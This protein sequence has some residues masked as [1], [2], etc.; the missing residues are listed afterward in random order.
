MGISKMQ[1]AV[2]VW[3]KRKP[4]RAFCKIKEGYCEERGFYSTLFVLL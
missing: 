2:E 4:V 1:I 3:I